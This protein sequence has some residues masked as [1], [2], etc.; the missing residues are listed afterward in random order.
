MEKVKDLCGA[1]EGLGDVLNFS[2]HLTWEQRDATHMPMPRTARLDAPGVLH[3]IIIRGI[4]RRKLFKDDADRDNLVER[5]GR[6]LLE[7]NTKCYA[8]ALLPN[9]A[10]FLLRTGDVALPTVMRRLLT[11]YAVSFNHRHRR[12]GQL[13]QNRYKSIVCQE[14]AY[15]KELVRYIH[16][17]PVRAGLV[18]GI[19]ELT[20][21]AYC[22]HGVVMGNA[23]Q[24]WQDWRYLLK[25]FSKAVGAAR[26][27][28]LAYVTEGVD[29]GRRP[30]LVGGGVV[31]STGGWSEVKKL[32]KRGQ[33]RIKG[34]ERILGDSEFVMEVLSA[35]GE[36]ATRPYE[37]KSRGWDLDRVIEKVAELYGMEREEIIARGRQRQRVNA[38]SLLCYWACHELG[39]SLTEAGKLLGMTAPGVGY[40]V[41]R[42]RAIARDKKY[43]LSKMVS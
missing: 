11:G 22:G 8:W 6:L 41:Q 37:L 31:R 25:W 32:R 20:R 30:E 9:H 40:A 5:L 34:D 29:Q 7:T 15:F 43:D 39:M 42:G 36:K 18:K 14:D 19:E 10:H 33:D 13:F 1:M 23:K 4:E 2:I 26:K 35:A 21:Y 38:R 17:N 28:Y 16:L 27:R 24:P 12:H 3:H